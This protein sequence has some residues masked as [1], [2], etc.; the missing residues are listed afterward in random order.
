MKAI[1][2]LLSFILFLNFSNAAIHQNRN[3]QT[4]HNG[5][6]NLTLHQLLHKEIANRL[7]VDLSGCSWGFGTR[8]SKANASLKVIYPDQRIRTELRAYQKVF[9]ILTKTNKDMPIYLKEYPEL[10]KTKDTGKLKNKECQTVALL[11]SGKKPYDY[12]SDIKNQT[13]ENFLLIGNRGFIHPTGAVS[14]DCGY[15]FPQEGCEAKSFSTFSKWQESCN[16][17]MHAHNREWTSLFQSKHEA[18]WMKEGCQDT[19]EHGSPAL[20]KGFEYTHHPKVFVMSSSHDYDL[21]H[22]LIESLARM[23]SSFKSLKDSS[24]SIHVRNFEDYDT[25]KASTTTFVANAKIMRNKFFELLGIKSSRIISGP[26]LATEVII[27]RALKCN[28]ISSHALQIRSLGKHLLEKAHEKIKHHP[29]ILNEVFDQNIVPSSKYHKSNITVATTNTSTSTS[30]K[31][32]TI[33]IVK[34]SLFTTSASNVLSNATYDS[35]KSSFETLFP[36]NKIIEISTD[37]LINP[38][39]CLECDIIALSQSHILIGTHG[40]GLTNML[41]LPSPSL[42]VEIISDGDEES[43]PVCGRYGPLAAILGHHH[44]VYLPSSDLEKQKNFGKSLA[45][46]VHEFY[47]SLAKGIEEKDIVTYRPGK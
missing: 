44:F 31:L 19:S 32:R 29:D 27:P 42:V 33:T 15:F 25:S 30:T 12:Y 20:S 17:S 1:L 39:G 26:V 5:I 16:K 40:A 18:N 2:L 6:A 37:N 7:S 36:Q 34:E 11:S 47:S 43:L 38:H 23:S 35:I 13:N 3:N 9:S 14:F 10:Q 41:Y 4:I 21:F 8:A 28:D 45:K 24:I 22:F 46:E